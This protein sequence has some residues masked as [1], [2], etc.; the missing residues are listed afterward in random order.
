MKPVADPLQRSSPG[1]PGRLDCVRM[2]SFDRA[3]AKK[4]LIHAEQTIDLVWQAANLIRTTAAAW[5]D[6]IFPPAE[7]QRDAYLS[8]AVDRIDLEQRIRKWERR[9]TP[10][11]DGV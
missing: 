1:L 10:F 9:P 2:H 5:K 4:H 6:R 3:I 8:G 11:R 7:R